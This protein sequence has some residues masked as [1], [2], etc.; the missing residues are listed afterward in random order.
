MGDCYA[1]QY[2]QWTPEEIAE[3]ERAEAE[4]DY[5]YLPIHRTE[6]GYPNCAICDGGGCFDCTDPS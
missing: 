2:E 3:L 6:A 5:R 1:E 4:D